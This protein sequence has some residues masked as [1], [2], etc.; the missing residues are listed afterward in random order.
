[1]LNSVKYR[2][3]PRPNQCELINQT[4]GCTRFIYNAM[5]HDFY[6]NNIIKTPAKYKNDYPF[7]KNVDSL[8]LTNSQM[9]LKQAFRNYKQNKDHFGKPRYKKK[10]RSKLSYHLRRKTPTSRKAWDERSES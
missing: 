10:S 7:L 8:A 2:I 6:E 5:L 3:Y 9:D 4:I 1:M